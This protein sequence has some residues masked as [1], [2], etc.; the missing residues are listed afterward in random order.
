M[1]TDT[2]LFFNLIRPEQ[3]YGG[4]RIKFYGATFSSKVN[5]YAKFGKLEPTQV[6]YRNPGLLE[7][8]IPESD[9]IGP[10]PV[11]IVTKEGNLLCHVMR[12]FMHIGRG[13]ENA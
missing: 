10:V 7:G 3:G 6:I 2:P 1:K 13:G 5:Y 12:R 9:K 8:E 4:Q 11:S